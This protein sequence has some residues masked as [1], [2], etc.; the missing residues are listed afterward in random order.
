M[1]T[2]RLEKGPSKK[3]TDCEVK[4]PPHLFG[5]TEAQQC[6]NTYRTFKQVD[7]RLCQIMESNTHVEKS[8]E[9]EVHTT[10]SSVPLGDIKNAPL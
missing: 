3:P 1:H 5:S 10:Y 4:L 7:D 6:G 2:I 8:Q 9:L